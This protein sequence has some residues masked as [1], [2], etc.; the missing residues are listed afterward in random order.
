[1]PGAR[2]PGAGGGAPVW[3]GCTAGRTG[4]TK[5]R[6]VPAGRGGDRRRGCPGDGR[7][8]RRVGAHRGDRGLPGVCSG[9]RNPQR[10]ARGPAGEPPRARPHRSPRASP[11]PRCPTPPRS[12]APP[13][14]PGPPPSGPGNANSPTDRGPSRGSGTCSA[15]S[16]EP[17]RRRRRPSGKVSLFR[18]A[19]K[20]R[21]WDV[22]ATAAPRPAPPRPGQSRLPP[23]PPCRCPSPPPPPLRH[24]G[25]GRLQAAAVPESGPGHRAS[26]RAPEKRSKGPLPVGGGADALLSPGPPNLGRYLRTKSFPARCGG[27]WEEP[28]WPLLARSWMPAARSGCP[29]GG[30]AGP[31]AQPP[32]L[33]SDPRFSSS[34]ISSKAPLFFYFGLVGWR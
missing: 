28:W 11:S 23:P 18:R 10:A 12:A 7:T 16:D 32:S 22:T 27:G 25:P 21:F 2:M 8:H 15:R 30:G 1:M 4:I 3:P 26:S 33:P 6:G 34:Q 9:A 31:G 13:P 14:G 24:R 17:S 20:F 19:A 29:R 5:G